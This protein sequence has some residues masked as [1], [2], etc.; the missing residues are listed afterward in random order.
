MESLKSAVFQALDYVRER[1]LGLEV[2]LTGAEMIDTNHL[3]RALRV[4]PLGRRNWLFAWTELGARHVGI[5]QSLIVTCRLHGL[6]PYD[7]L[8]DVI[9]S[10]LDEHHTLPYGK[11]LMAHTK[12]A[13]E[14]LT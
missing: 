9:E 5:V 3:E 8:V 7:Y 10:F 14:R 11:S 2:F 13:I 6:G 4:F 12:V 1:R